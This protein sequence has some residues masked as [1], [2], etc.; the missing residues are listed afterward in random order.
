MEKESNWENQQSV[1]SILDIAF[2]AVFC[3]RHK[4]IHNTSICCAGVLAAWLTVNLLALSGSHPTCFTDLLEVLRSPVTSLDHLEKCIGH[5]L[6][7]LTA[8]CNCQKTKK[9]MKFHPMVI[10]ASITATAAIC[11]AIALALNLG[12][13][14]SPSVHNFLVQFDGWHPILFSITDYRHCGLSSTITL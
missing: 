8:Q 4:D 7:N 1:L 2:N 6:D 3:N 14:A 13:S 12:P 10:G 11:S 9:T 5:L